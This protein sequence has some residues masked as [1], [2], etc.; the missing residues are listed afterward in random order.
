M[1]NPWR[2]NPYEEPETDDGGSAARVKELKRDIAL[3]RYEVDAASVADAII[4]KI[5]LV[6]RARAAI[7][8]AEADRIPSLSRRHLRAS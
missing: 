6:R 5:E 3:A 7:S 1:L 4:A 2:M 8:V